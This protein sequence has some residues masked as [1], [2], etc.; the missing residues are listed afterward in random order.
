MTPWDQKEVLGPVLKKGQGRVGRIMSYLG[1][2]TV[3][4]GRFHITQTVG[5]LTE[6]GL[7][8]L[9]GYAQGGMV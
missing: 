4:E 8:G 3:W 1:V 2:E 9:Q 5:K 6:K 7:K